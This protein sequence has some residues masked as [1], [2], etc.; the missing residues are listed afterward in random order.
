MSK[1]QR[2]ESDASESS[3]GSSQQFIDSA[4]LVEE[5]H[6][7]DIISDGIAQNSPNNCAP[8]TN[9]ILVNSRIVK[10]EEILWTT[11]LRM[12]LR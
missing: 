2:Q 4:D 3:A 12:S 8:E 10:K 6:D 7:S 9:K 5:Q 1:E 11:F